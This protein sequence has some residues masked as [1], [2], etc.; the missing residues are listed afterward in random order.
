MLYNVEPPAPLQNG[1]DGIRAGKLGMVDY[2]NGYKYPDPR[3]Q[4]QTK[5]AVEG[6]NSSFGKCSKFDNFMA[7]IKSVAK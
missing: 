2:Y 6:N 7:S 5:Q 3:N 1:S 4:K